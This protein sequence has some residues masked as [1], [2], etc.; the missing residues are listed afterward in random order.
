MKKRLGVLLAM[1]PLLV[2]FSCSKGGGKDQH[3]G[4][5]SSTTIS[6]TADDTYAEIDIKSNVDWAITGGV[7][8]CMPDVI[9]GNGDRK[10]KLKIQ[11][12]TTSGSREVT[13]TVGSFLGTVDI[14]VEQS[15]PEM[16]YAEGAYKAAET[17]RQTD[18]VNIVIMG[19]GFTAADMARGGAYDQAM[20]RAREA[21]FDI[22]PFKSYRNYFN[23][24][25]VYAESAERGATYGW[26][27]D[28]STKATFSFTERNTAF[29]ATFSTSANSTATSC[30]YQKVFNYARKIPAIK[31]GADIVLKP[32]GNIQSGAIADVNNVINKTLVILVINDTRY[33]GTCVM[34]PTGAAIGMCP[35]STAAGNMSFE[36]TL[37]HEAGG[38]GFG[39][40]TDEYIYSETAIPQTSTDGGYS[41][42]TLQQWQ[43]LG[44]YMNMSAVK[45]KTGAPAV[46]QPFLDNAAIYP[47][48]D[49]FEGGCTYALGIWRAESN[50]IM[51]DN[52]PY[53][54]G[55]QR[56]FIYNRIKTIAGEAPTWA[57]F[58]TRD[59]QAT[60]SQLNAF[61]AMAKAS[62]SQFI[63]LG[64]PIMM[65]MPL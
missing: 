5:T 62:E 1:L 42:N 8:W 59:V 17:N 51:N 11:P 57:D 39:K 63:P 28:G 3:F 41:L 43:G 33:A 48:V 14:Y 9:R 50:S 45:T 15:G 38:H 58:R 36:A 22:E 52:V 16:G 10:V 18:P 19:D 37:R 25:Y 30:N 47:E 4:I 2:F 7:A 55:P 34:Y 21:F 65:D 6:L 20:D 44:Y 60:P 40:F 29:K 32:D 61:A 53:F 13:L 26:G 56:Y 54:N 35:M 23:V 64:R 24:Y 12:K 31:E 49:F 46:W 27:Y